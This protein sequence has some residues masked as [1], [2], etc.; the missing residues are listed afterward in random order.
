MQSKP[1]RVLLL[2]LIVCAA[3]AGGC[4]SSASISSWQHAVEQYVAQK[5]NGDPNVLRDVTLSGDRPGFGVIGED[6]PKKSSDANAL[7]LGNRVVNNQPTFVYL[8]G[9]VK[10]MKVEE[11]RVAALQY[12]NGKA[13]WK[14]GHNDHKALAAYRDYNKRLYRQRNPQAS[15]KDVPAEYLT[16][17][18]DEDRF[19]LAVRGTTVEA[20]HQQS[21]AT[22]QVNVAGKR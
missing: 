1:H 11:I 19:D 4:A 22:W 17:P 16:F 6:D 7:L 13:V 20:K 8:I 18:R 21:G 10:A 15:A 9:L 2:A 3:T 14:V 5:G 12:V